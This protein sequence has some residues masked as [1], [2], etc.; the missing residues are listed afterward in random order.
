MKGSL[1]IVGF[2]ALGCLCGLFQVIPF[3][4]A[5]PISVFMPYVL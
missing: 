3:D 5:L 2:F 1:I 4:L